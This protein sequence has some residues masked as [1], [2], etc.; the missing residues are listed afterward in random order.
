MQA[1]KAMMGAFERREAEKRDAE[2]AKNDLEAYIISTGG[3]LD[4][5]A[6]NEVSSGLPPLQKANPPSFSKR[7]RPF[8]VAGEAA[9][10]RSTFQRPT[11]AN[12]LFKGWHSMR[13]GEC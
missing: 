2:R 4:D 6:F 7:D 13:W 9:C 3:V 8:L 5:G 11:G 1:G 10:M 12:S